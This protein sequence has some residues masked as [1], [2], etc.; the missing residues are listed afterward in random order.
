MHR[1]TVR[2]VVSPELKVDWSSRIMYAWYTEQDRATLDLS[3]TA[4]DAATVAAAVMKPILHST[5]NIS[6][7]VASSYRLS[8][9]RDYETSADPPAAAPTL[10][11]TGARPARQVAELPQNPR[12]RA[13]ILS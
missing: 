9:P 5:S 3:S 13:A 6:S 7:T 8:S 10:S 2:S 12:P 4:K 11:R 1:L